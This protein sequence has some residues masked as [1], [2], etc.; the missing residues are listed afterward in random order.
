[1]NVK[2]S[3]HQK[4]YLES[5]TG[6]RNG[7]VQARHDIL[8]C[9]W[10]FRLVALCLQPFSLGCCQCQHFVIAQQSSILL[11]AEKKEEY[12]KNST[13]PLD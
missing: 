6:H 3:V 7:Y 9:S 5:V 2:R 10:H 1:M 4:E 11:Q 12:E 13:A 8:G